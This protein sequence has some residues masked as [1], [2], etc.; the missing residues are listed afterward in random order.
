MAQLRQPAQYLTMR[1]RNPLCG[2]ALAMLAMGSAPAAATEDTPVSASVEE[3]A[4]PRLERVRPPPSPGGAHANAKALPAR[5]RA[6]VAPRKNAAMAPKRAPLDRKA[7][8]AILRPPKSAAAASSSAAVQSAPTKPATA[9]VADDGLAAIAR[10]YCTVNMSAANEA[11]TAWQMER[12]TTLE[13]R[14]VAKSEELAARSEELRALLKRRDDAL[15]QA[16]QDLVAIFLKMK[17][18]AAAQQLAAMNENTAAAI[19]MRIGA[20]NASA[21]FN[22]MAAEKAA[23]IATALAARGAPG[24]RDEAAP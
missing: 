12:L 9:A 11:R 14:V 3:S 13:S 1:S 19:L 2:L 4:A 16:D 21:V 17:P 22:E 18:D 23:R 24:K 6:S 15:A 10:T 20:R 7:P 5:A 8:R